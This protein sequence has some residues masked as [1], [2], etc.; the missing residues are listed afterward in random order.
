MRKTR[1]T[2]TT[3][4]GPCFPDNLWQPLQPP[5]LAQRVEVHIH[6]THYLIQLKLQRDAVRDVKRFTVESV[7]SSVERRTQFRRIK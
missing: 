7:N 4:G 2:S 3:S 1:A 5:L 6:V